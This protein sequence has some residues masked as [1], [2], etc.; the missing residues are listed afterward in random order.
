MQSLWPTLTN[1]LQMRWISPCVCLLLSAAY[2]GNQCKQLRVWKLTFWDLGEVGPMRGLR[3]VPPWL[4]NTW[5]KF[6][7]KKESALM[8]FLRVLVMKLSLTELIWVMSTVH[9]TLP[10]EWID[11]LSSFSTYIFSS[12]T[13]WWNLETADVKKLDSIPSTHPGDKVIGN[14]Y[15]AQ[16]K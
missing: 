3:R 4:T 10:G 15:P 11:K 1:Y 7:K 5:A 9:Q 13:S 8:S 2:N 16:G 14:M 12:F 6:C